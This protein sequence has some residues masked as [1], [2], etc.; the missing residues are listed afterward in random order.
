[1]LSFIVDTQLPPVLAR[2][3]RDKGHDLLHH[4]EKHFGRV[5]ERFE[6]GAGLV[7]FSWNKIADY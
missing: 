6:Q 4:F 7:L 2:W 1:M 3:L 5:Q